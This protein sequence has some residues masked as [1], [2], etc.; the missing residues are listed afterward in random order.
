MFGARKKVGI[1]PRLLLR[2]NR[3]GGI[4]TSCGGDAGTLDSPPPPS[5]IAGDARS[6]E[7][8]RA[9]RFDFHGVVTTA[10]CVCTARSSNETFRESPLNG[11]APDTC[12]ASALAFV[13]GACSMRGGKTSRKSVL[14]LRLRLRLRSKL[15]VAFTS[16]SSCAFSQS[17]SFASRRRIVTRSC[18]LLPLLPTATFAACCASPLLL[19][20]AACFSGGPSCISTRRR[21]WS[22]LPGRG[23]LNRSRLTHSS[24]WR[25]RMSLSESTTVSVSRRELRWAR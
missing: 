9:C 3:R 7:G 15:Y 20:R 5:S 16:I 22:S 14:P 11:E 18:M 23:L 25:M 17:S 13:L 4:R 12:S 1:N 10:R 24:P 6:E 21:S 19:F 8:E 2:V